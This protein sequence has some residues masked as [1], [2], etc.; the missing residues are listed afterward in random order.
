MC[1]QRHRPTL[2]FVGDVI[3]VVVPMLPMST[4]LKMTQEVY[5]AYG[6]SGGTT[7]LICKADE[8]PDQCKFIRYFDIRLIPVTSQLSGFRVLTLGCV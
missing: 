2:P 8:V 1:Q 4:P 3:D 7:E 6:E 5:E